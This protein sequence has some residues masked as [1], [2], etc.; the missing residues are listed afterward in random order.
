[1]R[2]V[3]LLAAAGIALMAGG[4]QA[5]GPQAQSATAAASRS[6]QRTLFNRY[7]LTCHNQT[8]SA[9]GTVPVAFEHLDLANIGAGAQI[10]EQVVRKMRA[11]VMPPA[12]RPR[13]DV[14]AS[15]GFVSWLET[16]LD[17]AAVARPNPGRI[18]AFHRLNR[19]EYRNAV[20]DLLHLDID[21]SD[22]SAWLP[23]DD[24]SY[25]FDNIAAVLRFS[26]TLMERYLVAAKQVSRLAVGMPPAFPNFDV[27][28]LADDLPQDDRF[29][30]LPFGT[31]GGTLIHY[32]FPTAG[33]YTIRVKL[34]RQVGTYDGNVPNFYQPQQL[35][36]SLDGERLEVF[37][38]AA[39]SGGDRQRRVDLRGVC[40]GSQPAPGPADRAL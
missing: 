2:R 32:N 23:A 35:E 17:A 14:P 39:S 28:R 30:K 31:R 8:Q 1:M 6:P 24:A 9:R 34:A 33:E 7:C 21:A 18:E 13:P 20:R 22:V 16:E 15:E 12:G 37:T 38:L 40:G 36:V 4:L 25:G 3:R 29:E 11:G 19:A 26:P 27:F 5:A 10:W